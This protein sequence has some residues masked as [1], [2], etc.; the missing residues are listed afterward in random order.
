MHLDNFLYQHEL[1]NINKEV[2]RYKSSK[3]PSC[4]DFIS[5]DTAKNFFKTNTVF[6]GLRDFHKLVLFVFKTIF[7]KP[8]SE[9]ITY[10]NFKN[11]S[12]ENFNKNIGQ[13]LEKN[14]FKI[15]HLLKSF[16]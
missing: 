1:S 16:S 14:V 12:E 3:N 15:I 7:S 4:I 10:A 2:T 8:N 9:E 11:F 5:S 13:I 6:T